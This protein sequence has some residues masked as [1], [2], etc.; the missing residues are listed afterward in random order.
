MTLRAGV[1]DLQETI[2]D[3]LAE[4]DRV[5]YRVTLRGTH[6]GELLGIPATGRTIAV[7]GIV[8][9]RIADGKIVE[10]WNQ[11]D[12]LGLMRTLGAIPAS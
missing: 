3:L 5:A 1:P 10:E 9:D 12:L 11:S 6:L 2:E 4:G 7:A 8:I